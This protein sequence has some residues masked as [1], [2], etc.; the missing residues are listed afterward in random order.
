MNIGLRTI[1]EAGGTG[2][3]HLILLQ[4]DEGASSPS[5][6]YENAIKQNIADLEKLRNGVCT[7]ESKTVKM[8][9]TDGRRVSS[10]SAANLFSSSTCFWISARS[11]EA[12]STPC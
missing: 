3:R 5:R 4:F 8:W 6:S 2:R 1:L 11:P 7:T 12:F 9:G 10:H